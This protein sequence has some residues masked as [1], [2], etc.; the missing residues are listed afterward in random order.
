MIAGVTSLLF[1]V[2]VGAKLYRI[3]SVFKLAQVH[4][5]NYQ[6]QHRHINR[7][8]ILLPGSLECRELLSVPAL[9][10]GDA[11]TAIHFIRAALTPEQ[12]LSTLPWHLWHEA[13]LA[14]C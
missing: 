11:E 3:P 5:H 12:N 6:W 10:S 2:K 8:R 9:F 13:H 4:S 7:S 14:T 1:L